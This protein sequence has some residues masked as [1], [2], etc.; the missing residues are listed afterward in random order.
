MLSLGTKFEF[1]EKQNEME[2]EMES[3]STTDADKENHKPTP[4]RHK[5]SHKQVYTVCDVAFKGEN[6]VVGQQCSLCK[7]NFAVVMF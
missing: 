4:K 6:F 2:D 5:K 3:G 1:E 7:I